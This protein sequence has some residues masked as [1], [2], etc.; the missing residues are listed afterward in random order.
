MTRH[1][2]FALCAA[3]LSVSVVHAQQPPEPGRVRVVREQTLY[4]IN[5]DGTAVV[6]ME[7]ALSPLNQAGIAQV[8]QVARSYQEGS[9]EMEFLEAYT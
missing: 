3:W 6:S 5:A 1:L 8:A 9:S 7:R 4:E 2:R